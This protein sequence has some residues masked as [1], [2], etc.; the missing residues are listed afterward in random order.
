MSQTNIPAGDVKAIKKWSSALAADTNAKAYWTRRF[1]G[2]TENSI[3]QQKTELESDAGELIQFDL[4]V[5]LR[6]LPTIGDDRMKGKEENLRFF[7]DQVLIDQ[8]R[9]PVS[10]GGRMSRKRTIHDLRKVA[11]DRMSDYWAKYQ[12]E[13]TFIYLSG[14]RGINEDY[15]QP[16][17]WT[18]FAGN[19]LQAPD[20]A[21]VMYGG[22]ATSKAT[23]TSA[24][25]F[26]RALIE[27]AQTYTRMI[28]ALNPNAINMHPVM[29]NGEGNYVL[30]MSPFQGH[31]LRNAD[32]G[33][34]VDMNKA[35]IQG[36]DKNNPIFKGGLG[37]LAK[38]VLHEH[39][40]AVRFSDYGAGGNLPAARALFLGRQAG[41]IAYGTGQGA[42]FQWI[43][44]KDDYGNLTNYA[45]GVI[46]GMKKARFNGQ[47]VGVVALDTYAAPVT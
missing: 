6:G 31:Q 25:T 14:A 13:M 35:L 40:S 22:T 12:D 3:I 24:D 17:D 42:R 23:I 34:W 1:I 15:I 36:G 30:V 16:L 11:K 19:V 46:M 9:K 4:S 21:H 45:S 47:D 29:F 18:G 8:M 28:R 39:D 10:I 32:T 44:E 20:A 43:E 27:R 5:Q 26:N 38:T 37:M 33:G 2:K 7:T 41:I